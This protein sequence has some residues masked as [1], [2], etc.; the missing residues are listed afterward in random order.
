MDGRK[1][2][3]LQ[4]DDNVV[5]GHP[6]L[7]AVHLHFEPV[8]T[9]GKRLDRSHMRI[10]ANLGV[11]LLGEAGYDLFVAAHHGAEVHVAVD[12]HQDVFE[13]W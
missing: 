5:R 10:Q 12:V 6:L 11:E 9:V 1:R 2:S 4:G 8:R 3:Q 13:E 7:D